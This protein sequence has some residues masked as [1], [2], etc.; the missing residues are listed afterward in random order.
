MVKEGDVNI[1]E[2][3]EV[4]KEEGIKWSVMLQ[5]WLSGGYP[6]IYN[7]KELIEETTD[8]W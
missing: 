7:T 1:T 3:I 2:D 6:P 4:V 8:S 5:L